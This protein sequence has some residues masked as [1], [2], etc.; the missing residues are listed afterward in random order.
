MHNNHA[1][2]G[3]TAQEGKALSAWSQGKPENR[4]KSIKTKGESRSP[5]PAEY[6]RLFG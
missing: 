2:L 4:G 1:S 5:K 6:Q 3:K